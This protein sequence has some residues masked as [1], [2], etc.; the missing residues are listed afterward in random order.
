MLTSLSA[1]E[2][3]CVLCEYQ[4]TIQRVS[5]DFKA[6]RIFFYPWGLKSKICTDSVAE[7]S[8]ALTARHHILTSLLL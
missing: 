3:I 8:L 1:Q 7:A 6:S 5:C 2:N 4:N